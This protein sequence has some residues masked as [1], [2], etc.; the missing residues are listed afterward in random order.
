MNPND[1]DTADARPV[2]YPL[3]WADDIRARYP[4]Y[5][6][7]YPECYGG[8]NALLSEFFDTVVS[9]VPDPDDFGL[10]QVKEK[11]GDLRIY[12]SLGDVSDDVVKAINEAEELAVKKSG[13]TCE[14][15]GEPGALIDRSGFYCVRAE[16]HRKPGDLVVKF[17]G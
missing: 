3:D 13:T 17:C 14:I 5:F 15:S 2:P 7:R 9:L 4:G 8:W 11:F 12:Y 16:K 1:A 10:L 6:T